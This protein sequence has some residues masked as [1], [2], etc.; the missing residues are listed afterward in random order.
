M[1]K[2][3][4]PVDRAFERCKLLA[5]V[6]ALEYR[7]ARANPLDDRY[8]TLGITERGELKADAVHQIEEAFSDLEALVNHLTI[9]D[10]AAAFEKMF[11]ARIATAVGEARKTLRGKH[12][13]PVL[14][15]RDGIVREMEDFRGLS[16]ITNLIG[17]DLDE[18][19]KKRIESVRENRNRFAHGTD[20][21]TPPTIPREEARDALNEAVILL[22]P[23]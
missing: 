7:R 10:M 3:P 8:A 22:K 4:T 19:V 9:L 11:N 21:T 1:A 15:G 2:E 16:N 13:G 18:Q 14:A 17:A 6:V 12:R 5:Q 20:L 23:M